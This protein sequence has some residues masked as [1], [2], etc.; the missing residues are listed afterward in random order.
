MHLRQNS[1]VNVRGVHLR[2]F[3]QPPPTGR[4]Y[5]LAEGLDSAPRAR[6]VLT[7]CRAT[8]SWLVRAPHVDSRNMVSPPHSSSRV[9]RSPTRSKQ[10]L[11]AST[12]LARSEVL[13]ALRRSKI[14]KVADADTTTTKLARPFL[15]TFSSKITAC[16]QFFRLKIWKLRTRPISLPRQSDDWI[17]ILV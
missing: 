2:A 17:K 13:T 1:G 4:R 9:V 3:L 12:A 14:S 6:E 10:H 16:K 7:A 5:N 11:P 15:L 8:R